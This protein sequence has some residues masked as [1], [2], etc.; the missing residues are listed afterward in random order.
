MY[1][2]KIEHPTIKLRSTIP[3][4]LYEILPDTLKAHYNTKLKNKNLD[5][6]AYFHSELDINLTNHSNTLYV[7]TDASFEIT[8]NISI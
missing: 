8:E 1:I 3:K 4:E 7:N 2:L 5:K 6:W